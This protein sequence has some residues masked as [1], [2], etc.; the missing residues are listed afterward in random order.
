VNDDLAFLPGMAEKLG[1]YVYALV[2]PRDNEIFYVGKGAG[3][4]VYQHA[5]HARVVDPAEGRKGLKLAKIKQ[6]H[7]EGRE[8][9]VEI[10]RHGLKSDEALMVEAAVIDSLTLAGFELTNLVRGQA[11]GRGWQP[12]DDLRARYAASRVEID[13]SDH[14]ILI[15]VNKLFKYGMSPGELYEAT[16]QWWK[17]NP[18]R[19][20]SHA[21]AVYNGIVRAVYVIDR[22]SGHNGWEPAPD[23]SAR[24]RF[25]G[26]RD[27]ELEAKY[28]WRDVRRYLPNGAQNPVRYVGC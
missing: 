16:R 9:G 6:I 26:A 22:A 24:W 8:V 25:T 3:D 11:R 19:A 13:P 2:D 5:A 15:R 21:C 7:D 4:R 14:V 17:V 18:R 12:L 10:I 23:G 28:V 20:P 27:S 1:F